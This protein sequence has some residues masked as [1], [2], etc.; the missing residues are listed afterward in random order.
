MV[1][2]IN[3][4]HQACSGNVILTFY[5]LNTH[6]RSTLNVVVLTCISDKFNQFLENLS[7]NIVLKILKYNIADSSKDQREYWGNQNS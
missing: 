3:A 4:C 7:M 5:G 2:H 6:F 1:W